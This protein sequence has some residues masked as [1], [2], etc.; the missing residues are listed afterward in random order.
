MAICPC[1]H[2]WEGA[3]TG[4]QGGAG[5]GWERGG[6]RGGAVRSLY[7]VV[8]SNASI[9]QW[10]CECYISARSV[11]MATVSRD[12]RRTVVGSPARRGWRCCPTPAPR[13]PSPPLAG[14][15][16]TASGT[17]STRILFGT[18][19]G[20][21]RPSSRLPTARPRWRPPYDSSTHAPDHLPCPAV[22]HHT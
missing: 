3:Q 2:G 19:S 4:G 12:S 1:C 10:R 17:T 18:R 8:R 16:P 7:R 9:L 20:G 21:A 11:T 15:P 22:A 13:P 14:T 6:R 5:A